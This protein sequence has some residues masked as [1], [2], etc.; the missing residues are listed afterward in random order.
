MVRLRFILFRRLALNDTERDF[1]DFNGIGK[2]S[3]SSGP[4]DWLMYPSYH[5]VSYHLAWTGFETKKK[6]LRNTAIKQLRGQLIAVNFGIFFWF[7]T[8]KFGESTSNSNDNDLQKKNAHK[9]D[10]P[11]WGGPLPEKQQQQQLQ[12][13]T[14]SDASC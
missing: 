11:T 2:L 13:H 7:S 10:H 3:I 6:N 4:Y 5:Y 14:N 12:Q 1:H 8:Y 9:N